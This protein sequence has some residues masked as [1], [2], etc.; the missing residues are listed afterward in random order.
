MFNRTSHHAN[1]L[2]MAPEPGA[3]PPRTVTMQRFGAPGQWYRPCSVNCLQ[4]FRHGRIGATNI[5]VE[6]PEAHS[7]PMLYSW[8]GD[9][10]YTGQANDMLRDV[11]L[12]AH[13]SGELYPVGARHCYDQTSYYE[14][15]YDFTEL[16][17]CDSCNQACLSAND[18][19]EHCVVEHSAE[20]R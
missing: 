17:S 7:Q 16:L 10:G 5:F 18:L 19:A 14:Q 11:F 12:T 9:H 8:C 6:G 2:M 13:A 1:L 3:K 4:T 20:Q 15:W